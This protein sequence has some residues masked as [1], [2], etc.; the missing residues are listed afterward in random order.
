MV[1]SIRL[2]AA[3]RHQRKEQNHLEPRMCQITHGGHQ[4][5]WITS[6]SAEDVKLPGGHRTS[7][8]FLNRPLG[9]SPFRALSNETSA[10]QGCCRRSCPHCQ[11][12]SSNRAGRVLTRHP[13]LNSNVRQTSLLLRSPPSPCPLRDTPNEMLH[14]S[15]G[16][17]SREVGAPAS[18]GTPSVARLRSLHVRFELVFPGHRPTVAAPEFTPRRRPVGIRRGKVP[19]EGPLGGEW[20]ARWVPAMEVRRRVFVGPVFSIPGDGG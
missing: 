8:P 4:I 17:I 16:F 15:L 11:V 14:H 20:P 2:E 6:N 12:S 3:A 9:W 18:V 13:F 1:L 5:P 19:L 10:R 7:E